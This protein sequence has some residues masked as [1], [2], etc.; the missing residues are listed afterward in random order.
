MNI[1]EEYIKIFII[2]FATIMIWHGI[3]IILNSFMKNNVNKALFN[4]LTG[5]FLL[6]TLNN[7]INFVN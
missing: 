6:S 1:Y 5:L 7:S 2:G 3:W 4:I